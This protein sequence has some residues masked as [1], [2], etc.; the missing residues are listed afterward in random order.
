VYYY[1]IIIV[2]VVESLWLQTVC[3]AISLTFLG[4]YAQFLFFSDF[5]CRAILLERVYSGGDLILS[6][7]LFEVFTSARICTSQ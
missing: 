2:S 4:F 3:I 5:T 6:G 7:V 1:G